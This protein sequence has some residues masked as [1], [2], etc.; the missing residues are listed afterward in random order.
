MLEKVNP[1]TLARAAGVRMVA[2]GKPGTA[3]PI[4][5]FAAAKPKQ[6]RAYC[7]ENPASALFVIER[8]GAVRPASPPEDRLLR[9]LRR[10]G[11]AL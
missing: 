4:R 1:G 10:K 8:D 5:N 6:P 3:D 2:D 9:R 7:A 11:G